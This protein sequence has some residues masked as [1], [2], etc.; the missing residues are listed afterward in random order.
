M[1]EIAAVGNFY[2][3]KQGFC[4]IKQ[5]KVSLF[6]PVKIGEVVG[7]QFPGEE[8]RGTGP[9]EKIFQITGR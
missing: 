2:F 5:N 7:T 3:S 9:V 6:L 8:D 4:G 1:P